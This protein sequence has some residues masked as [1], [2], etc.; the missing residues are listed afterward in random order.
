MRDVDQGE[1]LEAK[2]FAHYLPV[3]VA[4]VMFAF[5]PTAMQTSCNG[6]FLP[7]LGADYGVP[8][9]QISI[10]LTIGNLTAAV[11][12]PIVGQALARFD[13]R[14][15][16]TVMLFGA[17]G[18]FYSLSVSASLAQVWVSGA[19]MTGFCT[20][21][22]GLVNPTVLTRWFKDRK[23][24][25]IGIAAAF[26]GFGG[27]VFI[28]VGQGIIDAIGY[29]EAYLAYAILILVLC[30]PC[31]LFA[32]RSHPHDRGMLPYQSAKRRAG[33]L[34]EEKPGM[35]T[36]TVDPKVAMKNPAF[37]LLGVTSGILGWCLLLNPHFPTYVGT[38]EAAG[39]NAI[40]SGATLAT[41]V[42]GAQGVGKLVLG[43]L[44]DKSPMKT[45]AFAGCLGVFSVLAIWLGPTSILMP[46]GAVA[47]GFFFATSAVL[48]PML[49]GSVFGT[50]E[51]YSIVLG[52]S[53]TV[54]KLITAPGA[55]VWPFLA[56]NAGGWGTVFGCVAVLIVAV[57]GC[58]WL[59]RYFG[60]SIPHIKVDAEGNAIE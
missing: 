3:V 53:Q 16:T 14:A 43:A 1:G 31:S 13:V 7:E 36:W 17:A 47:F 28:P 49:A 9:S 54:T 40:I 11:L 23:G 2:G 42:S 4:C 18:S 19:L 57:V 58:A 22:V 46:V 25:M 26:T 12:A 30:L 6:I 35:S 50:G 10:Y 37:Y 27:V 45:I 33:L 32:L 38:L 60:R 44:S 24:T 55:M 29:R 48:I 39:V 51:N 41:I 8:T 59:V 56:E 5:V 20:L 21:F 15:V 34:H 52:R